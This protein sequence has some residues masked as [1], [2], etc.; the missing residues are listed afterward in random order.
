MQRTKKLLAI[1]IIIS[2]S[3]VVALTAQ[4]I[5]I[6]Q[7]NGT[8]LDTTAFPLNAIFK[9][10]ENSVVQITS[11]LPV[12]VLPNPLSPNPQT[13]NATALGSGFVYDRQGHI[14]T[15]NHVIAGA[16]LVD[17]TFIDGN[18]YT[19][20]VIGAD[21]YSDLAV[22]KIIEN[23]TKP[24]APLAIGN[25]STL[26]VGEQVIAIGNP[27]GFSNTMTTGIISQT[28]ALLPSPDTGFSISNVILTDAEINPGNSGGPLLNL[29]G[30]VIGIN[31]AAILSGTGGFSVGFAIPS[32]VIIRIVPTLIDKGNYSH[33]YIGISGATLTSDLAETINGLK[34]NIKGVFINT[35]AKGGPA[36]KAGLHG[37]TIDQYGETHGGDIITAIDGRTVTRIEDFVNYLEEHKSVGDNAILTVYRDGNSINLK[38]S[39]QGRP[40]TPFS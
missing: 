30:Q 21:R 36:D 22:L 7:Q 19:A 13:R 25:S 4:P 27:F 24:P 16:K 33:P 20:Q 23:I 8:N 2:L 17:L 37:S 9:K 38:T 31:T 6:A 34:G 12:G 18:R 14:I 5:V 40:S 28:G 15:N 1:V 32:N 29:Q 26:G 39:L 3:V 10:V 11:K 35:I